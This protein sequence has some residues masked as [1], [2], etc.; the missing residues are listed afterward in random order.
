MCGRF[1]IQLDI[2]KLAALAGISVGAVMGAIG[3]PRPRY[4]LAPSQPIMAIKDHLDTGLRGYRWG[5][6]GLL[7]GWQ[8]N[9]EQ[10]KRPINARAESA[11]EKPTFRTAMRHHRVVVPASGFFEW[12][13]S[14]GHR[15]PYYFYRS[16]GEPLLLAGVWSYWTGVDGSEIETAA[17]LTTAANADMAPYHHRMPLIIEPSKLDA[18]LDPEQQRP[19]RLTELLQPAPDGSLQCHPVSPEVNDARIDHRGL[20]EPWRPPHEQLALF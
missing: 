13:R 1:T 14:Q 11:A 20:I 10:A 18:W 2:N 15:A 12:D 3:A 4:N 5:L 19:R 7:P 6:W 17:L 9:V 8:K 16:N